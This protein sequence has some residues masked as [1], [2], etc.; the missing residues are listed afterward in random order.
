MPTANT[1]KVFT[2]GNS[3]AVRLPKQFRIEAS[4]VFIRKDAASG[5]I[6]LSTRPSHGGWADFFALRD[7]VTPQTRGDFL[8]DRPMNKVEAVRDPFAMLPQRKPESTP[9]IAKK[10]ATKAANK[11]TMKT[12]KQTAK[13]TAK[14]RA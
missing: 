13:K 8:Q 3:Q 7:K 6:V 14:R 1:A 10:A 2:N 5:D 12:T 9:A 11:T 4:E